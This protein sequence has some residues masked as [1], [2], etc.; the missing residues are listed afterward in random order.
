VKLNTVVQ[1]GVNEHTVPELVERFRGSG[2]VVRF[3]EYMDV[4][5]RNDWSIDEVVPSQELV[6]LID[7][8]WPLRAVPPKYPGEVAT[9]YR[10]LDGAGEIGMISSISQ[11]FCGAC[12]RAR[13]SSEGMLYTCL[14]ATAGTDF[15]AALRGDTSDEALTQR[16]REVWLGRNDRYSEE[17]AERHGK[18]RHKIEMHYIG[19]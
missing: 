14:F 3:I 17:R 2:I 5:N 10:F 8:R 16:L 12:S 7:A 1:R 6:A 18:T 15:R 19:G 13:L 4:G 11:P 9:R